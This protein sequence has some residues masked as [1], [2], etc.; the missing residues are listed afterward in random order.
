MNYQQKVSTRADVRALY[1]KV[2]ENPAIRR[3][4]GYTETKS[5][6]WDAESDDYVKRE[7]EVWFENP[8]YDGEYIPEGVADTATAELLDEQLANKE[9]Q[10]VELEAKRLEMATRL[11][12]LKEALKICEAERD[13]ARTTLAQLKESLAFTQTLLLPE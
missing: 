4:R 11:E 7:G 9:R 8:A 13:E 2:I 12:Q 3:Y 5:Y 1:E 6:G 10:I